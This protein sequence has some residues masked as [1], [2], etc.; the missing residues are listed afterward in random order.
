M[1]HNAHTKRM[2]EM[3]DKTYLKLD[4]SEASVKKHFIQRYLI[5][6]LM[7]SFRNYDNIL[8]NNLCYYVWQTN[9]YLHDTTRTIIIILKYSYKTSVEY[10]T[11][12]LK[13]LAL[14]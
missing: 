6:N 2:I 9:T 3:L 13:I 4:I 11:V 10:N 12:Q 5:Q 8:H 1:L 14:V 7:S